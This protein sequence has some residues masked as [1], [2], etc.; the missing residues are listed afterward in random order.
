M[1]TPTIKRP[2]TM[3]LTTARPNKN[4]HEGRESDRD[5]QEK[6]KNVEAQESEGMEV[7]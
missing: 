7:A 2:T 4:Q 5:V 3:R 1:L 6:R